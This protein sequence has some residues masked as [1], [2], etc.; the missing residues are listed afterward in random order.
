MSAPN[1]IVD[2]H[3]H[4]FWYGKDHHAL[5]RDMDAHGIEY[6]WLL[7]WEIAPWED[8]PAF[9]RLLNPLNLRLDGTHAGISLRDLLRA[10]EHYPDR[11]VVGYCPHPLLGDAPSLLRAAVAIHGVKVCGEWK[12]RI[13]FDDPRCIEV[14]RVAGELKLPVVLHLDVPFGPGQDGKPRYDPTWYGGTVAHLERAIQACPNT[15]FVG[16]A[17][18]FW[19]EISGDADATPERYPRTPVTP[20]GRLYALFDRYPNLHADLSASGLMALDRDPAHAKRFLDRHQE[21]L[22]FGRDF[23]DQ[24]LHNFLQTLDLSREITEKI[25]HRNAERL[26]TR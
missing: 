2:S 26:V 11:F 20:G 17:P 19:R 24:N 3:Q 10:R 25:Y 16:H 12:F 14:F 1:R 13:P 23:P 22:L 7:T 15:V 4:T 21:R 8:D 18:G 6:A 9:H 5:V